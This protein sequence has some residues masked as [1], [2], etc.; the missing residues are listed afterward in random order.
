MLISGYGA[1]FAIRMD[2]EIASGGITQ[3]TVCTGFTVIHCLKMKK[4]MTT[5]KKKISFY[6][7]NLTSSISILLL[8]QPIMIGDCSWLQNMV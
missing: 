7:N 3:I 1:S 5:H 6:S 4:S 2:V 8:F